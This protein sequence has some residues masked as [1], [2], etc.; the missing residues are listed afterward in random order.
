MSLPMFFKLD[1]TF[2]IFSATRKAAFRSFDN[3]MCRLEV[4]PIFRVVSESF[5][6]NFAGFVVHVKVIVVIIN[7]LFGLV[8]FRAKFAMK[9]S[10]N[11]V[12]VFRQ[13]NGSLWFEEKIEIA[14]TATTR[15]IMRLDLR[16]I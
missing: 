9:D 4:E 1:I 8:D 13:R 5:F 12:A 11:D 14:A 3:F 16:F 2:V 7:F 10:V 15:S 6:A